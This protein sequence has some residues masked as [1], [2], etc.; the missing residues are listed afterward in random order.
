MGQVA[1]KANASVIEVKQNYTSQLLSYEDEIVFTDCSIR[2]YFDEK[3][4]LK[5]DRDINT[6]INL[7]GVVL[8][9]LPTINRRKNKVV[10][11]KSK[12]PSISK[13]VLTVFKSHEKNTQTHYL[14]V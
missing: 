9:L 2:E 7:K 4:Q 6:A 5:I 1:T 13:E 8:D 12:T 3:L 10:I 11:I 14:S